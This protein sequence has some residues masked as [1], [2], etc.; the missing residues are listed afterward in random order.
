MEKAKHTPGQWEYGPRNGIGI[1]VQSISGKRIAVA[2]L[3]KKINEQ[4]Q[5]EQVWSD[6]SEANARLIAASPELLECL[7]EAIETIQPF[8]DDNVGEGD[9]DLI[10]NWKKAIAKAEGSTQ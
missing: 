6:E 10:G 1:E 2:Y 9:G 5:P 3:P 7:K 8:I 4:N